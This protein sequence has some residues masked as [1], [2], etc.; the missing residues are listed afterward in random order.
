MS[1]QYEQ[2]SEFAVPVQPQTIRILRR[3]CSES[4]CP[5]ASPKN[6]LTQACDDDSEELSTL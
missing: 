5:A 2:H 4:T 3:Q 6:W 1:A